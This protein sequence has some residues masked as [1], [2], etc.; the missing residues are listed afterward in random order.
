MAEK[1]KNKEITSQSEDFAQWYVDICTKCGLMSYSKMKGFII[2]RPYGYAIWERIQGY[3]NT[4]FKET[5]HQNVYLPVL[6]P[7]SLLQKEK[8]H[9]SGFAPECATVTRGGSKEL[10]E[11]LYVR[12][13]SETLFCDHFKDVL[14]SYNDLPLLYNQWCSVVRWEKTTKPFLRGA[15]FLWQEGHTLHRT[16][17]EARHE[18]LKMLKIYQ[19]MGEELLAIPFVTGEKTEKEKFAGAVNTYSI[20]ALMKDGQALQSGTTHFFGDGFAKSYDIKFLDN[21]NKLKTPFQTSW[22]VSTRLIGAVIM[23]HGDDNGL[24]L[25]PMLAPTQVVIIPIKNDK[26]PLVAKEA[27]EIHQVLKEAGVRVELDITNKSPGFKFNKYEMLGYPLRIEIGPRNLQDPNN[28]TVTVSIR[29]SQ[30][31]LNFEYK[32]TKELSTKINKLLVEVQAQMLK[33]SQEYLDNHIHTVTTEEELAEVLTN[34][35]G[36][37]KMMWDGTRET[38]DY[39]KQK[40]Q[41][42]ARCLPFD[43]EP[44]ADIDP[45]SKKKAKCVCYFARAY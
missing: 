19:K 29:H 8:D 36:Y 32:S 12:P 15:E 20:E 11:V 23:V 40:Y 26:E 25:P 34:S 17:D 30:E 22:G 39:I 27:N 42:T 35:K 2:Y 24:S 21:D 18:T 33:V 38:E 10:E 6:I 43:A 9:V 28:K 13:T 4:K 31:K 16:E 45:V 41:A 37:A 14:Q 7:D 1:I 5:G 44:F 3:L